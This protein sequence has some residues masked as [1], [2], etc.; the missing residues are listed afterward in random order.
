M[1]GIENLLGGWLHI[2]NIRLRND[3]GSVER[4]SRKYTTSIL[5]L[6]A[7]L[8]SSKQYMG[9]P[10]DCW[11]PAQFTSSQTRY[12]DTV[13]WVSDTFYLPNNVNHVPTVLPEHR[14][15]NYYQWVPLI[16]AAQAVCFYMPSIVWRFLHRRSGV[17]LRQIVDAA[18][19]CNDV[20]NSACREKSM[21]FL[22]AH[23]DQQLRPDYYA[24]VA[25]TTGVFNKLKNCCSFDKRFSGYFLPLLYGFIRLF[26]AINAVC[27]IFFLNR[28]LGTDFYKFGIHA[29]RRYLHGNEWSLTERF[30]KISI[31]T[32]EMRHHGRFHNYIVQCALP[33]NLFNEKI[34]IFLW[35]WL[36]FVAI[37]TVL[38]SVYWFA[39]FTIPSDVFLQRHLARMLQVKRRHTTSLLRQFKHKYLKRDGEFVLQLISDNAGFLVASE[40]LCA[41]W[42]IQTGEK[43]VA[44][45]RR[46]S[47]T[48]DAEV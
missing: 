43:Q 32:F 17:N 6:L 13:C 23:L 44:A 3:D 14:R 2:R 42:T 11:C 7:I 5:L 30:P 45:P 9:D 15:I 35:F 8:V 36:V 34:F 16:L 12:T 10:I 38:A 25:N 28:L 20:R 41:L 33:I 27:Q 37:V 18:Q 21:K 4:L 24:R 47:S 22:I 40:L 26:Y 31:C 46:Q 39:D 1:V 48:Q 29:W 19:V